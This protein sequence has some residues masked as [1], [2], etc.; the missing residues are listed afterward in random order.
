MIFI[1]GSVFGSF[2]TL[3]VYRIPLGLDITHERSFCPNCNHKL[4]F[5]D[6]IPIFSYIF[7]RGKCRYCGEKVRIRYLV[8]EVLSGTVFLIAYLSFNMNF[9]YFELDKIIDFVAFVFFYITIVL[10]SGIDKENVK[11]E[12]SVLLFGIITQS[13][14]MLYL[15]TFRN[16]NIYRYEMYLVIML[17]LFTIDTFFLKTKGKSLYFVQ[18]LMFVDYILMYIPFDIFYLVVILSVLYILVYSGY[19]NAK[20]SIKNK[21][22]ILTKEESTKI[23]IGFCI[24][25]SAVLVVLVNNFYLFY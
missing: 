6:L 15:Y 4:N 12:K 8:L 11:I 13:L 17:L 7:L 23:G 21:P 22:D 20:A 1:M 16:C 24:G 10:I 19:K 3:A 2:F 14:Y 9:P 18:I 25:V 5:K